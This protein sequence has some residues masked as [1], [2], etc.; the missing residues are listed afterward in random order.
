MATPDTSHPLTGALHDHIAAP[1]FPCVGAKSALGKGQIRTFIA[2]SITSSWDDLAL[3]DA[4]AAFAADYARDPVLFQSFAA[5]FEGPLS[6]DEAGF[7]AA[8][9]ERLQ[10]L[11]DKDVWRDQAFDAR[12]SPDPTNPHFAL[13]F[14]GQGFFVVG[15]H[16]GAS[17]ESRR[18]VRPA[19]MFNAHDQ[20]ETLREQGR[21]E[22]LR[23]AILARDEA[24]SGSINP[25]MARHGDASAA[26]QYSG[27]VVDERWQCPFNR[28]D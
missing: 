18:F 3:H 2:R 12:V 13:S 1:D 7:E 5:I 23:A 14:G 22:K 8:L 25:M 26:P 24:Q 15:L 21:Y 9:W 20:F 16:P 19:I 11:T 4:L 17:R 10:S 6:L 28:G 27:R